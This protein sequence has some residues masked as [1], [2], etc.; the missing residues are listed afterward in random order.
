M[1]GNRT[2]KGNP[3]AFKAAN[4]AKSARCSLL[5]RV[6]LARKT[7]NGVVIEVYAP[8]HA[9]YRINLDDQGIQV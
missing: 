7:I 3:S 9:K 2:S 6:L 5:E 4:D 8:M 1:K